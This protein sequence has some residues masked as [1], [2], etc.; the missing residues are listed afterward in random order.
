MNPAAYALRT[1]PS[2]FIFGRLVSGATM[3]EAQAEL[4]GIGQRSAATHPET[5]ATLRP[6]VMPYIHSLTD[7][8]GISTW[9]VV[10]M[11]LIMNIVLVVVA[12]NVAVLVY[13]R[14]ATRQGE[15]VVRSALGASR[16]RIV[17]QLFIEA[18]VLSLLAAAVGL[19][20]AQIGITLGNLIM[21][22][23]QGR[24]FWMDY[25]LQPS[26]VFFTVGI[27]IAVA[28][29]VG[30]LPALQA[31]GQRL[32]GG[33]RQL[34]GATGMRLGTTWT[35]LIV[36]QVA[37]AVAALPVA[38]NMGWSEIR[39]ATTRPTY[40]AE[41]Y[42]VAQLRPEPGDGAATTPDIRP[43]G[44]R[45]TEVL[46]R[47]DAEPAVLGATYET[48]LPGRVGIVQVE[49]LSAPPESPVG[50]RVG[51]DGVGPNHLGLYDAGILT[52][53]DFEPGDLD[54][55][56]TV[57]IVNRA[58][59]SQVLGVGDALGRRV[60][61]VD[62]ALFEAG[63]DTA[64]GPWFEIVGVAEDLEVS[65]A[66]PDLVRPEVFYPVAPAQ[67]RAVVLGVRVRG[68]RATDFAARLREVVAVDPT[69]RLGTIRSLADFDRQERLAMM[70]VALIVGLVL[71]SV[72]L[73]S[74]AGIYALTSFTVTRRRREIGI[75]TAL[76]AHA[77]QVLRTVFARVALQIA[78]GLV[79]GVAAAAVLD[80]LTGG[81]L[82]GGRSGVLV[83]T[84]AVSMC[85]VAIVAAFG[86][87]RRGLRIQPSEALR[88]DA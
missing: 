7:I 13:A 15:I 9:S 3:E 10:Q 28:V 64:T 23:E 33:L 46:R 39:G 22:Q 31:T 74:A 62:P 57:V 73:L 84:F 82:L 29:I 42:L 50:H 16:R 41:E 63:T 61:F 88:A 44:D 55:A 36:A 87:A 49:G 4:T 30:L 56:S 1:G 58:F 35:V 32:Q 54:G 47:L 38:V 53:R 12:L 77:W 60:R 14:T 78:L 51:T 72:F 65:E 80:R 18:L 19:G 2:I 11:Q 6:M 45:L 24:P 83:P 75:R 20:L 52:G 27:A 79:I 37:L 8:Q 40:P 5:H 17:G 68:P 26:T 25:G 70:L 76:G 34:G 48:D 71:A 86:P 21:E 66:A 59:V 67:A 81:E 69:L 85:L 43:L